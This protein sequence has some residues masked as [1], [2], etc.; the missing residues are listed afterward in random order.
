MGSELQAETNRTFRAVRQ[1][2]GESRAVG[3]AI[4]AL[5]IA[6]LFALLVL[7]SHDKTTELNAQ[8]SAKLQELEKNQVR[9]K[10]EADE[11]YEQWLT[12]TSNMR[13]EYRQKFKE[14]EDADTE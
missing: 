8:L 7:Y 2:L 10:R 12:R 13:A 1:L 9:Y 11:R 3:I 5:I 4:S 6:T 14:I